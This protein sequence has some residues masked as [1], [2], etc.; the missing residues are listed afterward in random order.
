VFE[1]C[2]LGKTTY[3]RRIP[4]NASTMP[5][6][7]ARA[8]PEMNHIERSVG[9]PVK[10]R[11]TSE[12]KECDSLKPKINKTIPA[13]K[14]ARPTMF[15]AQTR[16]LDTGEHWGLYLTKRELAAVLMPES[17]FPICKFNL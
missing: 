17:R 9:F 5:A 10:N 4:R 13:A 11:E 1:N 14:I 3:V 16:I 6:M 7:T 15:M 12:P 2:R 8:P